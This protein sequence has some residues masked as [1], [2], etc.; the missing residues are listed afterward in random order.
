MQGL[1]IDCSLPDTGLLAI[2]DMYMVFGIKEIVGK[3]VA[4]RFLASGIPVA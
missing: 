2:S 3:P 4:K 1:G